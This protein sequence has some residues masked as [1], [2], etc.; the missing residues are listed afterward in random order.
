MKSEPT[1]D[2]VFLKYSNY[3]K[4]YSENFIT[5]LQCLAPGLWQRL[6]DPTQECSL[7]LVG[8][9]NGLL[10]ILFLKKMIQQRGS[11]KE[12]YLTCQGPS[13]AMREEFRQRALDSGLAN[14]VAEYQVVQFEETLY[15]EP[16][17]HIAVAPHEWL[18]IAAWKNTP[19]EHNSLVKFRNSL[20]RGGAG[21]VVFPYQAGDRF[22]LLQTLKSFSS[23]SPTFAIRDGDLSQYTRPQNDFQND[24]CMKHTARDFENYFETKSSQNL[25]HSNSESRA[26]MISGEEVVEELFY[27]QVRHQAYIVETIV[28]IES[29]FQRGHFRPNQDGEKLLSYLLQVEW[30]S[31]PKLAVKMIGEKITELRAH[32]GKPKM[33]LQN[34][35]VWIFPGTPHKRDLEKEKIIFEEICNYQRHFI[36]AK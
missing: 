29:C 6:L 4:V 9:K 27:L 13:S 18:D 1:S 11:M 8:A 32:Y 22:L 26:T 24:S 36:S 31:L 23:A 17:V 2:E 14:L 21:M 5:G 20:H 30:Q 7:Y 35:Y 28:N 25:I 15:V 16:L 34:L 10:E 19:Q 3:E 33:V 12:L